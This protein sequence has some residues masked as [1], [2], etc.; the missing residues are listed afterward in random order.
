MSVPS[1]MVDT[2]T[3]CTFAAGAAL[4][5]A[6]AA[7]ITRTYAAQTRLAQAVSQTT[8]SQP[9]ASV[10]QCSAAGVSLDDVIL[11]EQLTRN[12]QFF[13][14]DGQQRVCDAFVV[15]VGLGVS[16]L[17]RQDVRCR[18]TCLSEVQPFSASDGIDSSS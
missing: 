16:A 14:R 2:R 18:D 6:V 3:V 13:G 12:V 1:S 7:A 9:P 8:V 17:S 10:L 11:G 4:G 5:C 15:V